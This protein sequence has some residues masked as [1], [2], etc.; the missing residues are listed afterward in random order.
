M[1]M[2]EGW[3]KPSEGYLE[4]IGALKRQY[5]SAQDELQSLQ[6]DTREHAECV[7]KLAKYGKQI[8]DFYGSGSTVKHYKNQLREVLQQ[9]KGELVK[10]GLVKPEPA[11]APKPAPGPSARPAPAPAPA[12]RPAPQG[13]EVTETFEQ[14]Y[15]ELAKLVG[16]GTVKEEVRAFKAFLDVA[17]MRRQNGLPVDGNLS[18]HMCFFGPPGTG[19]TTVARLMARMFHAMGLLKTAN[20]VEVGRT[21]LVGAHIGETEKKFNEYLAQAMDGV[22][23]IDEAY[24]LYQGDDTKDFGKSVIEGLVAAAENYRDRLVIVLAGYEDEM[25][26][27]LDSNP[28]LASRFSNK[29]HF[30]HYSPDELMQIFRSMLKNKSG[31]TTYQLAPDGSENYLQSLLDLNEERLKALEKAGE[32]DRNFGNAR[33]IRNYYEKLKKVQATR[34]SNMQGLGALPKPEQNKVLMEFILEDLKN[35]PFPTNSI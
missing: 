13:E 12:P 26:D 34:I 10:F 6:P 32:A 16:L 8:C 14:V 1:T 7:V 29:I 19:K 18:L 27:L 35:V 4:K 24:Q 2:T 21:D 5:L 28:G 20:L 22:L 31:E 17:A 3:D 30:D 9:Y 11:P 23:F 33:E 15:A 25:K